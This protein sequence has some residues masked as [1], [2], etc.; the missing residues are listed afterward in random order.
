[1]T[2]LVLGASGFI[3]S[4]AVR[5][6]KE[7]GL[8]TIV[9]VREKSRLWRLDGIQGIEVHAVDEEHWAEVISSLKP[10]VIVSLDWAG[11]GGAHRDDRTQWQ[12]LFRQDAV[13]EVARDAGT[14]RFVGVGSQ[15][16]Y[17]PKTAKIVESA[18]ATPKTEYGKAKLAAMENGREFCSTNGMEWAWA[19]VFSVYG[20]LDNG[21]W[22]LP[23]IAD[24]LMADKDIELTAGLQ[25]WSYLYAADAGMALA[26][27]ATSKGV[28]GIYNL[29]NPDAPELRTSVEM[30]VSHFPTKA[31]AL[32]GAL[33]YG[34][35]P[36]M[37]LE[38]DVSRLES[39]GWCPRTSMS[40][41][42]ELTA[43]W[44]RG[45]DV[46]DPFFPGLLLPRRLA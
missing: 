19:R 20:P 32:F 30:F 2:T 15:A 11:V 21:H 7:Q 37:R 23:L 22:L 24:S 35:D 9:L 36:V 31:G 17:G 26:A 3:G 38:P 16:E 27:L 4:W 13:L 1:M 28:S 5:A 29:G 10:E 46:A 42:L 34:K 33:S 41:G 44:L 14:R 6:L 8:R 18:R 39:L 25:R 40:D 45:L 43:Q 12:N